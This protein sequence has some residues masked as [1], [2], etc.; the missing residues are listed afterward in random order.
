M[1]NEVLK[2][3]NT[4]SVDAKLNRADE[5]AKAF[6]GEVASFTHLYPHAVVTD[7]NADATQ[8]ISRIH[9]GGPADFERWGLLLGDYV[10]CL[11]SA[12]D[13][14]IYSVAVAEADRNPPPNADKVMMPLRF[15]EQGFNHV[16]SH[17]LSDLSDVLRARIETLQPYPDR[18]QNL[19]LQLLEQL[20][21]RDKHRLLQVVAVRPVHADT[22][23]DGPEKGTIMD[24]DL[25]TGPLVDGAPF[26][27]LTFDRPS[28]NVKVHGNAAMLI[29]VP[30]PADPP[31][32]LYDA[33][34]LVHLLRLE[35][36]RA[37]HV[38]LG[39]PVDQL[40]APA[41]LTGYDVQ[42]T[43]GRVLDPPET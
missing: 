26:L 16:W 8:W 28:P 31:T 39:Q 42:T 21:I 7:A 36:R 2:R 43:G 41:A 10:H 37:I 24:M 14:F 35:V 33:G 5:H 11:R 20:D 15:T 1:D 25:A 23:I 38:M 12:L 29:V 18:P 40:P 27:T 9:F 19:L 34:N 3:L 4:G 17:R 6:T 32:V 22:V 30:E 13:H